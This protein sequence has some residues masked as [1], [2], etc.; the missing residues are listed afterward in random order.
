[1]QLAQAGTYHGTDA[2]REYVEFLDSS[3]TIFSRKIGLIHKIVPIPESISYDD[4]TNMCTATFVIDACS[5][6]S[7]RVHNGGEKEGSIDHTGMYKLNYKIEKLPEPLNPTSSSSAAVI[8][9]QRANVYSPHEYLQHLFAIAHTNEVAK[10]VCNIMR[11]SCYDTFDANFPSLNEHE[12]EGSARDESCVEAMMQLNTIDEGGHFDGNSFACRVL[13]SAMAAKNPL[14]CPHISLL[15]TEDED[16]KIKCQQSLHISPTDLFSIE[17]IDALNAIAIRDF[18]YDPSDHMFRY[19]QGDTCAQRHPAY[20]RQFDNCP[21]IIS[22]VICFLVVA[23]T[24][25][26]CIHQCIGL[27]K[28]ATC[29]TTTRKS[30]TNDKSQEND[31]EE[32]VSVQPTIV[33]EGFSSSLSDA[34][35][36]SSDSTCIVTVEFEENRSSMMTEDYSYYADTNSNILSWNAVTCTY[37]QGKNSSC[38]LKNASGSLAPGNFMAIM[39]SSG[40]GKST[41]LDIISGRKNIGKVQGEISFL[42]TKVSAS[43]YKEQDFIRKGSVYIPQQVEFQPNQTPAEELHFVLEVLYGNRDSSEDRREIVYSTLSEVGLPEDAWHRPIGG[44][45]NGGIVIKGLSGGQRKK[46]ALARAL[47]QNPKLLFIDE[48]SR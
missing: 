35:T 38:V 17:D 10:E 48:I 5:S 26:A 12:E 6:L 19:I 3:S 9:I 32:A 39:G 30:F 7:D 41:L 42:G 24:F 2:I 13:H 15:P 20:Y 28:E 33:S 45:L 27:R 31:D 14:H 16:G 44:V 23:F 40:G 18:K 46:L 29:T 34:I 47:V 11:N 36:N 4:R 25:W 22:I 43:E 8:K 21:M 1:M 37:V